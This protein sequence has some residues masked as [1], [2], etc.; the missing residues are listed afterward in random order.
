MTDPKPKKP[1]IEYPAPWGYKVIGTDESALRS[2]VQ[3]CLDASLVR[4]T[5]D[6]EFE[7][8]LSRESKGGKYLSLS[9]NLTV[10]SEEERDGIFQ[11]LRNH[12]D[13]LMV[14]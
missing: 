4:D 5:G 11:A 7:L 13:V 9:L 12:A 2:A 1:V 6:R 10:V 14:M 3:E 8:G